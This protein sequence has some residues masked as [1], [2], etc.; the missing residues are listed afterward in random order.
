MLWA[1]VWDSFPKRLW[2]G[3]FPLI[4]IITIIIII[5]TDTHTGTHVCLCLHYVAV[6]WKLTQSVC[7]VRQCWQICAECRTLSHLHLSASLP[8]DVTS[9]CMTVTSR[10]SSQLNRAENFLK[11]LPR[12]VPQLYLILALVFLNRVCQVTPEKLYSPSCCDF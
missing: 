11:V 2:L 5:I 4:I 1:A 10:L 8:H 6:K 7:E 3:R 12:K 9:L